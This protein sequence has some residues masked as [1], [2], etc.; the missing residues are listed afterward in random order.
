[1]TGTRD[2]AHFYIRVSPPSCLCI[3]KLT[4]A[5][6]CEIDEC[7]WWMSRQ[8]TSQRVPRDK[9]AELNKQR[10]PC[11]LDKIT[12]AEQERQAVAAMLRAKGLD[13]DPAAVDAY[14]YGGWDI[15]SDSGDE[16]SDDEEEGMSTCFLLY[17]L[18]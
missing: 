17:L 11:A 10:P 6:Q 13:H 8:F 4:C 16:T 15:D 3:A 7:H 1:M 5:R 9:L 2:D 12:K 18:H 14:L